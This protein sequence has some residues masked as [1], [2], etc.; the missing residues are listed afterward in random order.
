MSLARGFFYGGTQSVVSSLWNVDD[1]S[2]QAILKE[3]YENLKNGQDK[4]AA[5]HNAKLSYLEENSLSEL[6]PYYWSS[7]ILIG[8][9]TPLEFDTSPW[10]EKFLI[11]SLLSIVLIFIGIRFFRKK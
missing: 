4:S 3:F 11:I 9:I 5:L 7:L 8:D 1:K 10:N 6:S 2:T